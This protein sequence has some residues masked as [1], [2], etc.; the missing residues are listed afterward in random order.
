MAR[1]IWFILLTILAAPAFAQDD[2]DG[3]FGGFGGD[4]GFGGF[5]D[6]SGEDFGGNSLGNLQSSAPKVDPLADIRNWLALVNAAPVDKK[7][8]KP[9]NSL[10][11]KEVKAMAKA[12]EKRFG[13][14]LD[15]AIAAQN[16]GRGRRGGASSGRTPPEQVAEIR[17]M[18]TELVDKIIAA[19]RI[20]QQ[21]AI[22]R[23]QSEQLRVARWNR[24]NDNVKSAG[25]TLTAD[26][27]AQIEALLA[28][29]SRL[30]TLMI[31]ESKGEPHRSKVAMLEAQTGQRI[32][33]LLD[34]TQ[35]VA[36]VAT[37]AKPKT[38]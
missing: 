34:E 1:L 23:Y 2:G 14:S 37:L 7:Q 3:G 36:L 11:E 31:V 8:E 9:L 5:G 35:K 33:T 28:R 30:R 6:D 26:Q 19:L 17:R 21:A 18:S 12:F 20:D 22:R 27:K 25:V 29:E 24:L 16:P 32:A 10:Y 4:G 13:V 38:P 15:S